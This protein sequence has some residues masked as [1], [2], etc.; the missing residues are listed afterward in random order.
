MDIPG[1][2]VNQLNTISGTGFIDLTYEPWDIPRSTHEIAASLRSITNVFDIGHWQLDVGWSSDTASF[3]TLWAE[4]S[5]TDITYNDGTSW[6]ITSTSSTTWV[7]AV[8]WVAQVV[9]FTPT[10]PDR[11]DIYRIK[12]NGTSYSFQTSS[13]WTVQQIVEALNSSLAASPAVDCTENDFSVTCTAKVA[14]TAFT[15]ESEVV[16]KSWLETAINAEFTDWASRTTYKLTWSDYTPASWSAYTWSLS[17]AITLLEVNSAATTTM[18]SD[19]IADIEAKKLALELDIFT[20]TYQLTS[21]ST[22]DSNVDSDFYNWETY[23]VYQRDSN[24]YFKK[25]IWQEELIWFWN[26]PAIAVWNWWIVHIAFQSGSTIYYQNNNYGTWNTPISIVAGWITPDLDISPNGT[27]NIVLEWTNP[28]DS[29][30]RDNILLYNWDWESAFTWW[31]ILNGYYE[32]LWWADYA[33]NNY[34]NPNIKIDDNWNYHIVVAFRDWSKRMGWS[35]TN[36]YIKYISNKS[37]WLT[38]STPSAWATTLVLDKNAMALDSSWTPFV[39]YKWS[40]W[41]YYLADLTSWWNASSLWSWINNPSLAID[42]TDIWI[43][44]VDWSWDVRYKENSWSSFVGSAL[45]EATGFTPSLSMWNNEVFVH[46]IKSDWDNEIKL[47]STAPVYSVPGQIDNADD[48]FMLW[49]SGSLSLSNLQPGWVYSIMSWGT[50]VSSWVLV[51]TGTTWSIGLIPNMSM[52]TKVNFTLSWS[53][54]GTTTSNISTKSIY[55]WF[56]DIV[57][58]YNNTIASSLLWGGIVNNLTWV[59]YSNIQNFSWLYFEKTWL[60]KIEFSSGMDLTDISTQSFLQNLPSYLSMDNWFV[61]LSWSAFSSYPATIT[62]YNLPKAFSGMTFDEDDFVVK[63]NTWGTIDWSWVISGFDLECFV[64]DCSI[65]F[66]TAHFTSFDLKPVLTWIS[67]R[68]NNAYSWSYAKYGDKLILEFTWSE[69]LTGTSIWFSDVSLESLVDLWW[70]HYRATS[71]AVTGSLSMFPNFS[72]RPEDYNWNMGDVYTSTTDWSTVSYDITN[73]SAEALYSPMW[74]ATTA[75][76]VIAT[77]ANFTE[78]GIVVTNNSWLFTYTFSSNWSFTFNYRDYA[79]NTWSTTATVN[80][81]NKSVPVVT[82]NWESEVDVEQ[83]DLYLDAWAEWIDQTDWSWTVTDITS[84]FDNNVLGSYNFQYI[85]VNSLWMTWSTNRTVNVVDTIT[86]SIPTITTATDQ[87]F[88]ST[89]ITITWTWEANEFIKFY[90]SWTILGT[91]TINWSGTYSIDLLL[92]EWIN[93]IV[94]KSY[95]EAWN[96][97][98]NSNSITITRDTIAPVIVYKQIKDIK[99]TNANLEI[100]VTDINLWNSPFWTVDFT[101]SGW[102]STWNVNLSIIW[103]IGETTL[104]PLDQ[105][106]IYTYTVMVSDTAWN[107]K[108]ETGTFKTAKTVIVNSD[109]TET[110]AVLL[111]TWDWTVEVGTWETYEFEWNLFINSDPN[112]D[113]FMTGSLSF[114]WVNI[115]VEAWEWDWVLIPPTLIDPESTE[116]ATWSEVWTWVTI[117]QTIK[118][119]SETAWLT[120]TWGLFEVSFMVP[121]Y[122][123]WKTFSLYRSNDWAIWSLNTPDSHCTLDADL[124]CTFETDHLS[125]FAPWFDNEPDA[126][127]F[128]AQTDKELNTLYTSNAITVNWIDTTA[129]ITIVL[130]EY[131]VSWGTYTSWAWTVVN[132][133]TVTVRRLSA[134]TYNTPVS[135]TL[136]IWLT[137]GSFNITTK[138]APSGGGG[139]GW[140]APT[141][142]KDDC[143]VDYSPSYYDKTCWTKPTSTWSTTETDAGNNNDSWVDETL[144]DNTWSGPVEDTDT[145][146]EEPFTNDLEKCFEWEA[147]A[148]PDIANSWAK[149]YIM[150]LYKIGVIDWKEWNYLPQSP[151]TRAEFIKMILWASKIDYSNADTS[152]LKF[153]DVKKDSWQ[154]KVVKTAIDNWLVD[155][156]NTL[157]RPDEPISRIEALKVLLL[158]MDYKFEDNYEK[159][160]V[161]LNED[162]MIKYVEASKNMWLIEGQIVDWKPIFRP[163]DN[164]TRAETSK[165]TVKFILL[166]K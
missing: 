27:V 110:G 163:L 38:Y 39:L 87:I 141:L 55:V 34:S 142:I 41:N 19:A 75:L 20:D 135:T 148:F 93:N 102:T 138:A 95:D 143:T 134:A 9:I 37:I 96:Y 8:T 23:A 132:W 12:I 62:M 42:W 129:A 106:D 152:T 113:D 126:F 82:L 33:S 15:Y 123:A 22:A 35:D 45:V 107:Q 114:S 127:N 77:L 40:D 149:C 97:S 94:A 118:A 155:P 47:T 105:N 158:A 112:D 83:W 28:W 119:W 90:N 51:A 66:D 29:W 130:W 137:S 100:K 24:I 61:S 86:P 11:I 16:D 54:N 52:Y 150:Y 153:N 72:I 92:E 121:W 156:N 21:N 164:I 78:P 48:S 128:I 3:T 74:P 81:I 154:A 1:A 145:L 59:T 7:V 104:S 101:N 70:N 146:T 76:D 165:I 159:T 89:W 117:I 2:D 157:F 14:G 85:Y 50:L 122:P 36:F 58:M 162:W 32:S 53:Y 133:D 120:A 166:N 103:N 160:F 71:T 124:M 151:T 140:W 147:L 109:K 46:Y 80:Y 4:S 6:D 131:S 161:D 116:A 69:A 18:V 139:G 125:F 136:T 49:I 57:D 30:D 111:D 5:A 31:V 10:P 64:N 88:N 99:D 60:W 68:S 56:F 26:T 44:Y 84:S 79:W 25:W 144:T 115:Y 43:A 63:S 67:Y 73:P 65:E 108:I 91:W 13:W 98:A 17:S